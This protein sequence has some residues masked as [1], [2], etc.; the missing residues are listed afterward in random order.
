MLGTK[1]FKSI[2]GDFMDVTLQTL[3]RFCLSAG[4]I[5]SF[6][7]ASPLTLAAQDNKSSLV[8]FEIVDVIQ[9]KSIPKSLTGK[10]GNKKRGEALM[11]Q[12]AKG[13]CLACHQ[14]SL[15]EEKAQKDPNAYGDMGEVG[16]TLD[17]VAERYKEGQLRL[18]LVDAKQV[19]PETIMPS[20]YRVE[21]LHLVGKK[22]KEKPIL[23]PQEIEDILS[24]LLTLK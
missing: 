2:F 21:N 9:S 15:F 20:F 13:N 19:F 8:K 11:I 16:P 14:V 4:G 12:R 22:F 23:E 6:V 5:V 7:I 10:R 3:Y 24:F 1:Q 17:K 18:L